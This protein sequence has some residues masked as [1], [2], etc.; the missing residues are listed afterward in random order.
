MQEES[1]GQIII[2]K[3]SNRRLYDT[4]NKRYVTLDNI[5]SLIQEGSEIKVVDTPTGEDISKLILIQVVLE[6]E[7]NKQD[8]LPVSF[9]HMLIKH[10]NKIAKDFFENSFLMMF[11]PYLSFQ[12]SLKKNVQYWQ[13]SGLLP[14]GLNFP[15]SNDEKEPVE[16]LNDAEVKKRDGQERHEADKQPTDS[17]PEIEIL[18]E[19]VKELD[20]KIQ[21]L[22]K[23]RKSK[24]K[25]KVSGA[26][27]NG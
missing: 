20:Y 17:S 1:A 22:N 25:K 21:S 3:Y 10:G 23:S 16:S 26:K 15:L 24:T 27:V 8:I 11:Q 19:K 7:K 18:R 2:K 9:L 5:A 12:D 14:P 4:S 13:G 6:S